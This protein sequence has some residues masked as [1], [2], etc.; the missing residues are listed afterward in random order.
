MFPAVGF[1]SFDITLE[2]RDQAVAKW[3]TTEHGVQY[4]Y[5]VKHALELCRKKKRTQSKPRLEKQSFNKEKVRT[6]HIMEIRSVW[7]CSAHH[8]PL[9]NLLGHHLHITLFYD[10]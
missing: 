8:A 4:R 2:D 1:W 3:Q 7:A 9:H 6:H 10:L 5:A